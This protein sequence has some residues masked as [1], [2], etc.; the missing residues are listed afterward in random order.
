MLGHEHFKETNNVK[1]LFRGVIIS[2]TQQQQQLD[3]CD[4]LGEETPSK[5]EQN[6]LLKV[7]K[8]NTRTQTHERERLGS[9]LMHLHRRVTTVCCL[10]A[11]DTLASQLLHKPSRRRLQGRFIA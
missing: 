4:Q 6:P 5:G 9:N 7:A 8:T 10:V 1:S 2:Q 3:N 11:S